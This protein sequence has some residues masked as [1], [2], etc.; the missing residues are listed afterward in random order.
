M[1]PLL[2]APPPR[3]I[4]DSTA[5]ERA[6]GR[7]E[8]GGSHRGEAPRLLLRFPAEE[9]LASGALA[10]ASDD[11]CRGE[12]RGKAEAEEDEPEAANANTSGLE[13]ASRTHAAKNPTEIQQGQRPPSIFLRCF[14]GAIVF[15]FAFF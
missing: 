11:S 10:G 15:E 2:S 12:K 1:P 7:I 6:R 9:V 4:C 3:G 13:L 5:V 14:F 8:P